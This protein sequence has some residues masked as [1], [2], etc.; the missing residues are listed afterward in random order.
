MN[1]LQMR[2]KRLVRGIMV[3]NGEQRTLHHF[4]GLQQNMHA[5]MFEWGIVV[6]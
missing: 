5:N 2:I 6:L 1:H 3:K 4:D